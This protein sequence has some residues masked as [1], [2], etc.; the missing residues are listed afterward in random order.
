MTKI[1]YFLRSIAGWMCF[2]VASFLSASWPWAVI[3]SIR[4]VCDAGIVPETYQIIG[5]IILFF[6]AFALFGF[7]KWKKTLIKFISIY[8]AIFL[9]MT[10]SYIFVSGVDSIIGGCG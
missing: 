6:S 5:F 7:K 4:G 2:T 3:V 1:I 10:Y 8:I 9:L